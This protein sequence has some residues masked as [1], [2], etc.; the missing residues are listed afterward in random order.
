MK[1]RMK[2][3]LANRYA[4]LHMMGQ[5][6]DM[7]RT[8]MSSKEMAALMGV[9]LPTAISRLEQMARDEKI[10]KTTTQHRP[11]AKAYKWSLRCAT[12]RKYENGFYKTYFEMW[13]NEAFGE[14][15]P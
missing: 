1:H 9:S 11:N 8:E 6:E 10:A 14:H 3:T 13:K 2:D 7:G 5:I 4:V 15:K 12:R